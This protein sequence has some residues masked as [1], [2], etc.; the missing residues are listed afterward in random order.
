M[1]FDICCGAIATDSSV[2][3]E[4]VLAI[5]LRTFKVTLSSKE[6]YWN[7]AGVNYPTVGKDG[8]RAEM[9]LMLE[10]IKA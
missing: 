2:R 1:F 10:R 6:V 4:I 3:A 5:I 7:V 9:P 8:S